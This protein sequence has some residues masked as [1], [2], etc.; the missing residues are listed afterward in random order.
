MW[1][2]KSISARVAEVIEQRVTHAQKEHDEECARLDEESEQK[3]EAHAT[4][5]VTK[6]IGK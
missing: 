5:M 6:V 3:K 1:F 2:R 4:S